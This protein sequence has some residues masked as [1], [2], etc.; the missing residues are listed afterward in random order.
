MKGARMV[1][2]IMRE[3]LKANGALWGFVGILRLIL[4]AVKSKCIGWYLDAPEINLGP[5]CHLNGVRFMRFGQDIA[6]RS[7]LWIEAVTRYGAN[8]FTPLIVIGDR[9]RFSDAVHITAINRIEIG[10]DVLFGSRVFVSDHN[11][12]RYAGLG[13]SSPDEAPTLRALHSDGAVV[14]EDK[15]WIGD[16][17]NIVGPVRIGSGSVIGANSVIRDDVPPRTIVAGAPARVLKSFDADT[18]RWRSV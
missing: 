11:H 16:N 1:V 4:K 9:V 3:Q 17:V 10:N 7:N 8:V 2:G 13:Q 15:V 6:A 12:G 18:G 5:G 14:I